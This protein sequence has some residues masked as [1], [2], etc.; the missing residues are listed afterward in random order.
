MRISNW[1]VR[2][3]NGKWEMRDDNWKLRGEELPALPLASGP[4]P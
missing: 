3:G 1:D 2:N 4:I